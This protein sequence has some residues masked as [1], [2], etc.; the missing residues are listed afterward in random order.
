MS[1]RFLEK[2]EIRA[3]YDRFGAMQDWQSFYEGAAMRELLLHGRFNEASSVFE[4]GCGTGAFALDLL[5]RHLPE[6]AS[7]LGVD[8]S[9]TM[10][11]LANRRFDPFQ[12]RARVLQ[13]DGSLRF[14][15][16]DGSFDRFVANYVLD[17]LSPDDLV[18]VVGEAFSLLSDEGLICLL[19]LTRGRTVVSRAVTWL[20]NCM[21]HLSP[22]I[23]GGCRPLELGGFLVDGSWHINY[24][25]VLNSFGIPS[26]I[27]IAAKTAGKSSRRMSEACP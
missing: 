24:H 3:F 20:W 26:E 19:S 6:S 13:T 16:P 10:T 11:A 9:S 12:D 4:L 21:H 18:G 5:Q 1:K 22:R 25:N 2:E 7:Y 17:L 27:V 14:D 8:L 23:V 15:F